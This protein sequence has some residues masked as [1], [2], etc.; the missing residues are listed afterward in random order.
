MKFAE[1]IGKGI[2]NGIIKQIV[3]AAVL[4]IIFSF[5]VN[6]LFRWF[7]PIDSTD[8]SKQK[9]SGVSVVTDAKTGIEYLVTPQGGIT[10]RKAGTE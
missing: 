2:A 3:L 7:Y 5:P 4:V 6:W 1:E 9:R 10:P 8:F